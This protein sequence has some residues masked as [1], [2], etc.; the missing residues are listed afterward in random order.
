M[1][2][3]ADVSNAKQD[4]PVHGNCT[5]IVKM[6]VKVEFCSVFKGRSTQVWKMKELANYQQLSNEIWNLTENG[7][8]YRYLG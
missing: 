6:K 3:T 5:Y 8:V 2:N 1:W 4:V 7:W